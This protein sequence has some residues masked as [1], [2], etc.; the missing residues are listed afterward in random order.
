M[1]DFFKQ[2]L[3]P[4]DHI[5][6][7]VLI[8]LAEDMGRGDLS[9][10]WILNG[11]AKAT[12]ISRE[13]AILAGTAWFERCF[14]ELDPSLQVS[15]FVE[16]GEALLPS[17]PVCSLT[18]CIHALLSAERCALNFLQT[19]SAT[20]TQTYLYQQRIADLPCKLL[21]TRKTIPG[22]R[23]AQKYAVLCGGGHNHRLGLYDF[24]LIKEN[25][26]MATGG[27]IAAAV[28]R[29]RQQ[30]PQAFIEVEVETL[31]E[32]E[33]ALNTPVDRIMLDNFPLPMLAK[34]VTLTNHKTQ[35][36]ASGNIDLDTIRAVAETGVDY[37]SVGAL[38]KHVKAIDLSMR[39]TLL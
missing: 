28:H 11:T 1:P 23:L 31:P 36:E 14:L 22:L 19:L 18:G 24:I 38:T 20:A 9:T 17:Q 29:A 3:P 5:R 21:D 8:A 33:I 30:Y 2:F 27:S 35:L 34:A 16:D 25:H 15:W 6:Q 4:P 32:L 12:V 39:V 7:T 10:P 26:I 13:F 37:I